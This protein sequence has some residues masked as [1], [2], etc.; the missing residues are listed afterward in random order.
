MYLYAGTRSFIKSLLNFSLPSAAALLNFL[1]FLLSCKCNMY[2]PWSLTSPSQNLSFPV[3]S[4]FA[5]DIPGWPQSQQLGTHQFPSV[6]PFYPL[7]F[8]WS[9]RASF[10]PHHCA[11]LCHAAGELTLPWY[12]ILGLI[13]TLTAFSLNPASPSSHCHLLCVTSVTFSLPWRNPP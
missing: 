3:F 7:F 13:P 1:I 9:Y 2:E 8:P 5:S 11:A 12:P 10:P 4:A 6:E